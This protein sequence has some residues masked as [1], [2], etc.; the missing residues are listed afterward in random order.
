MNK[1]TVRLSGASR[2]GINYSQAIEF[3]PSDLPTWSKLTYAQFPG[4][5]RGL[6]SDYGEVARWSVKATIE[7]E[8]EP[9]TKKAKTEDAKAT[10]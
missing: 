3:N 6:C 1:I 9:P 10:A 5:H 2:T 7:L 8:P 4:I